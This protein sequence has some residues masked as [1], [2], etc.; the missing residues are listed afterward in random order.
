M[1]VDAFPLYF[2]TSASKLLW[3]KLGYSLR[4]RIMEEKKKEIL[5]YRFRVQ[6]FSFNPYS[7]VYAYVLNYL[8][9][10]YL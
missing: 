5:Y 2:R 10:A 7:L 1:V 3:A 4:I 6:Y 9:L 8:F